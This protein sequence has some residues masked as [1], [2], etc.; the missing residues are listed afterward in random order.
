MMCVQYLT[1][2]QQAATLEAELWS[3]RIQRGYSQ[4]I[5]SYQ[6]TPD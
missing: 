1:R 5:L 4:V 6:K 2:V 3:Q